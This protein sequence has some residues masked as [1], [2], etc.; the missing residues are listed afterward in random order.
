MSFRSKEG[1]KNI[2]CYNKELSLVALTVGWLSSAV[3]YCLSN[4][5]Q[6]DQE[7]GQLR[8]VAVFSA[9]ATLMQLY[10]LLFWL[11]PTDSKINRVVTHAAI[12]T[13]NMQ[14]LVL[15]LCVRIFLP[16]T[17]M[18]VP[19]LVVC[20]LY[21]VFALP[22]TAEALRVSTGTPLGGAYKTPQWEWNHLRSR[23]GWSIAYGLLFVTSLCLT[24]LQS[25]TGIPRMLVSGYLFIS[26]LFSWAKYRISSSI[27]RFW[28]FFGAFLPLW[29]LVAARMS[30]RTP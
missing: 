15:L 16:K 12:L 29:V 7:Q 27:G 6:T 1:N 23:G 11:H 21:G 2:M 25:F 18:R 13:N 19:S 3:L 8:V 28:C 24:S 26:F 4:K 10:D 30:S 9:Y 14:P 22:Q 17:A 20:A 5:A